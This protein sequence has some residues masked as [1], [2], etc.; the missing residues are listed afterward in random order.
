MDNYGQVTLRPRHI[1]SRGN[2]SGGSSTAASGGGSSGGCELL[3][4]ADATGL[5]AAVSVEILDTMGFKVRGFGA[6]GGKHGRRALTSLPTPA[7][8]D[9]PVFFT[10]LDSLMAD[11]YLLQDPRRPREI[12]RLFRSPGLIHWTPPHDGGAGDWLVCII[13]VCLSACLPLSL[14]LSVYLD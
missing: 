10:A 8:L 2:G 13:L 7:V 9:H 1:G 11:S 12:T 5:G 6:N 3:I 4:N 14:F